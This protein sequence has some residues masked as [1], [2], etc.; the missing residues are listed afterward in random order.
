[1]CVVALMTYAKMMTCSNFPQ[2][3]EVKEATETEFVQI[4]EIAKKEVEHPIHDWIPFYM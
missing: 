1:M 4:C 2:M 3:E